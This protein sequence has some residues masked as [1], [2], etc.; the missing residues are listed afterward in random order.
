MLLGA[1]GVISRSFISLCTVQVSSLVRVFTEEEDGERSSSS[2]SSDSV[3][4]GA[5]DD[6]SFILFC[7]DTFLACSV[8][9][10]NRETKYTQQQLERTCM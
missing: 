3:S 10:R 9:E 2:S 4:S 7:L 6:G 8:V 5:V 1:F